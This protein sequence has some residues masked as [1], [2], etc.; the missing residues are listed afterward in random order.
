MKKGK[1]DKF[2]CKKVPGRFKTLSNKPLA[3]E[4]R[5]QGRA[6]RVPARWLAGGKGGVAREQ[7]EIKAHLLACL[8]GVQSS[9]RGLVGDGAECGGRGAHRRRGFGRG[10]VM[11]GGGIA[12]LDYGEAH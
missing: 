10:T 5:G 7:E 9:W 12:S 1:R 3:G 11:R 8:D 6:D 2:L 4:E